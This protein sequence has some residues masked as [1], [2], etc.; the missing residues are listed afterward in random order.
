MLNFDKDAL[1]CDLAETYHIYDYKS[2]PCRMVAAFS[3]GLRENSRIKM[4]M[5]GIDPMPEQ[6]LMA[7]IADGTRTT[8]WLQSKDGTTGENR[9]KSLLA[10]M[11]FHRQIKY[12]E[13]PFL[14]QEFKEQYLQYY[15]QVNCYIGKRTGFK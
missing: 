3:C 7:A 6:I 4:K 12:V 14:K 2:L 1:L 13:E 9:P 15:Q 11:M 8:A 10:M 5:A